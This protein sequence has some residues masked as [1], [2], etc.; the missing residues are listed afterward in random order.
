MKRW[1]ML[2]HRYLGLGAALAA[3]MLGLSGSLLL[4]PGVRAG[5]SATASPAAAPDY[6]ALLAAVH[7]RYPGAGVEFYPGRQTR[8]TIALRVRLATET[9]VLDMDPADATFVRDVA[10]RDDGRER[11]RTWH[12][13]LGLG[14]GGR[15]VAGV[16]GIALF[17]LT[18]SGLASWW[19]RDWSRAWR[20]RRGR[21][22]LRLADWHRWCGAWFAPVLLV[23]T[24]S[25]SVLSFPAA[26]PPRPPQAVTAAATVPGSPPRHAPPAAAPA[27]V[28]A[29]NRLVAVAAA[30]LP[31]ARV[32][33]VRIGAGQP[34]RVRL[35]QPGD[36]HPNGNSVVE[37]DPV[38][39]TVLRLTPYTRL[40]RTAR[41]R[42]W[43][44]AVHTGSVGGLPWRLTT[45]LAGLG[46]AGFGASGVWQWAS[47]RRKRVAS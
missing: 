2:T 13:T 8:D 23:G 39:G 27:T 17:V 20:L 44:Y 25:G 24:L 18:L 19:P 1:M 15:L 38:R 34:L 41:L 22:P 7:R 3:L 37:I 43:L 32:S 11:L 5:L 45:L 26:P 6:D 35:R 47:R 42:A 12:K 33:A 36:I 10:S 14:A 31:G 4:W 9:R 46:L 40:S 16:A 30:A 21:A 29:L 28:P